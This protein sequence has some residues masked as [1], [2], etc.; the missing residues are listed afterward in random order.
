MWLGS[1]A[2]YKGC[3]EI[4]FLSSL[5]SAFPVLVW[6]DNRG[7]YGVHCA[8]QGWVI[9]SAN[10]LILCSDA[11]GN[12]P[13]FCIQGQSLISCVS[14]C[15][16]AYLSRATFLT[17]QEKISHRGRIIRDSMQFY[18]PEEGS[19]APDKAR[20]LKSCRYADM[21][22]E[23]AFSRFLITRHMRFFNSHCLQYDIFLTLSLKFRKKKCILGREQIYEVKAF[24]NLFLIK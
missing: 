12:E 16:S 24:T 6:K 9:P 5:S 15:F 8:A 21:T 3:K 23:Q 19:I 10:Q 13:C 11:E 17:D 20:S 7:V 4:T 18:C 22:V 14:P 1:I 2:K